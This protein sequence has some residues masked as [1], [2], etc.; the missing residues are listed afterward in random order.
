[1]GN[2]PC[3][4]TFHA[5]RADLRRGHGDFGTLFARKIRIQVN[6]VGFKRQQ[7]EDTASYHHEIKK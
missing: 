3:R 2:L 6:H 7:L 4:V 5:D 1:M